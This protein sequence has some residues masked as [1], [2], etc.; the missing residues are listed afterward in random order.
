MIICLGTTPTMQRSMRFKSITVDEVNR[1]IMVDDYASGKSVNCARVLHS[2]GAEVMCTG[3][4]GGRYAGEFRANL[5][6]SK[7]AHDFVSTSA[8][9]RLCITA[10]DLSAGTATELIEES[11][12]VE[13][14]DVQRLLRT[15]REL[16]PRATGLV[17]SG[18]LAPNVPDN[19]Y[20][21]CLEACRCDLSLVDARGLALQHALFAKPTV[22]KPNREE[23]SATTQITIDSDRA[24]HQA[25]DAMH[26]QGTRNVLVTDGPRP[27]IASDGFHRWRITVPKIEVVSPIGSGDS[28]AAGIVHALS[29]KQSFLDA[30]QLGLACGMA[31]ALTDRA[32]HLDP[33]ILPSLVAKL[34]VHPL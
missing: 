9:T 7:I 14:Q 19:F 22:V 27:A 4:L 20:Q 10:I 16:A 5:D 30:A 32:G 6:A 24:L 15:L 11:S 17:L 12:A 8:P 3:F 33:H 25:I 23:L 2:L 21:L 13:V 26:K 1:A 29:Q 31:N 18:S 34:A 28:V